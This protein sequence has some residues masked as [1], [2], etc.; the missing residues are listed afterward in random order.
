[1]RRSNVCRFQIELNKPARAHLSH[2]RIQDTGLWGKK[3]GRIG[4]WQQSCV[5][6]VPDTLLLPLSFIYGLN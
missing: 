1:M 6:N 3:G 5:F 2:D 4:T